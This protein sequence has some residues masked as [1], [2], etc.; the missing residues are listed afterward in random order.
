MR[1]LLIENNA[2]LAYDIQ[3]SLNLLGIFSIALYA[4]VDEALQDSCK[5][6]DIALLRQGFVPRQDL[7]NIWKLNK[8][9]GL[10]HIFL[11]G[12][13]GDNIQAALLRATTSLE[14][15][16]HDILRLPLKHPALQLALTPYMC[17]NHPTVV[18][19]D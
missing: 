6:Y 9:L 19:S 8:M 12:I 3:S 11:T 10:E 5:P 2:F 4:T 16:L 13:Y 15:P 18:K 1:L 14:L 7:V 17:S